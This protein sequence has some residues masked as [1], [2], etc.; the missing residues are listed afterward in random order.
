MQLDEKNSQSVARKM[1]KKILFK[2]MFGNSCI[3]STERVNQ[4]VNVCLV[5]DCSGQTHSGLLPPT[6][7][8]SSLT[9]QRQV[10]INKQLDVLRRNGVYRSVCFCNSLTL[11]HFVQGASIDDLLIAIRKVG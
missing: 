5:V 3:H 7:S 9:N 10:S 1:L 2:E 6:Q 4:E 11:S 8:D